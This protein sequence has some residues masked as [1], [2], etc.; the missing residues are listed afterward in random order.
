M[1]THR[2]LLSLLLLSA[3]YA[4]QE[5]DWEDPSILGRNKEAPHATLAPFSDRD[6]ALRGQRERSPW[7]RS[8][9]GPWRFHW[10]A[11][12]EARP[13]DFQR[14]DFDASGWDTIPVPSNWQLEGHGTPIYTNV[15]YP[16][17]RDPPRV[18]GEVPES[19]TKHRLPNPVGSYR[20]T[21]EL[22]GGWDGR[23]VFLHFDGVQSAFYLW[24]NGEE[25]GYSQGSMTPAEF[26]ITP[27]LRP[28]ENVV[29]AQVYRWSDGS[30]LEDQD[31]WRLSGI[32]RDV[33]LFST[34]KLH[35]AD[36]FALPHLDAAFEQGE[37]EVRFELADY[38]S[39]LQE[40]AVRLELLDSDG[41]TVARGAWHGRLAPDEDGRTRGAAS[42]TV[43]RPALWSAESPTLYRLLLF[44][45]DEGG[46]ALEVE[47][48]RVGFRE[49]EIRGELLL[50][51]GTPVKLK[52]VNRH[53]HDPDR[54]HAI[55]RE[56]M[57]QDI[58]L[59]K[60]A[61]VNTVRTSHYPNQPL[62]YELC[63]QYGLYVIDEANLESHGMGYGDASLAH[64]PRWEAAHVDRQVSM[65]ER[66]KNHPCV[67]L[68]SMGNEAG[69]GENFAA[70]R[71]AIR[72]LDTSRPIH[73]E[74]D[75]AKADLDSVMYPSV[76]WLESAGANGSDRPLL[77]CEYA[78]AMGN[79]VGNLAEYWDTIYRHDR[80]LGGCIWDWVDQGLRRRNPD[81]SE[82]FLYGG[83][84][85]DV[86]NDGS[87]CINGLVGPDRAPTP[88][89][90]EV[91]HVY[92]NI[93]TRPDD[94]SL[95]RV[96]IENRFAFTNLSDFE[97][98]WSVRE[99]GR[100]IQ[101]GKLAALTIAPGETETASIPIEPWER[102]PGTESFL[103]VSFHLRTAEPWAP[104]GFEIA[105]DQLPL[106]G[107]T[108]P[109]V[110][111]NLGL[112]PPLRLERE[113]GRT[114][115]L[116]DGFRIVFDDSAAAIVAWEGAG[117]SLLAGVRARPPGPLLNVYRAP[118]NNDRYCLRPWEQEELWHLERA[119][120]SFEVEPI[121]PGLL[122]VRATTTERGRG[123][124]HFEVR[125]TWTILGDG[126]VHTAMNVVPRDAPS[127]LARVGVSM[128]LA[129]ALEELEWFGRG[130]L[131][132]YPD[133][134]TGSEIDRFVSS[135][136]DQFVPY[137][138]PQECGAKCDV[139]WVALRDGEGAGLLVAAA[140][141]FS[142]TAL[143]QTSRELALARHPGD[144]P[145]REDTVL[146]ID[147]AVNGLGGASCGPRPMA[148]YLLR[149]EPL[150]FSFWMRPLPIGADP[151]EMGRRRVPIAPPVTIRRDASGLVTISPDDV[152]VRVRVLESDSRSRPYTGPF[153]CAD[154]AT[155]EAWSVADGFLHGA[156][157]RASFESIVPRGNWQV[158]SVDSE[159]P[160]EGL[161]AHAIDGDAATFWH[162]AW[163]SAAPPPPHE[164]L[165]DLGEPFELS[166]LRI[167]PRQDSSNG[168]IARFEVR[169]ALERD[170]F[171]D[172]I[173][174]GTLVD[175]SRWQEI[176]FKA[177]VRARF[178]R[179][180]ALS[181]VHGRP[182]TTI[183]ELDVVR[184]R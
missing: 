70:C 165:L 1:Q 169:A 174:S 17:H 104:A 28:G 3:P 55:G 133:R 12:P 178:L 154:A 181:E 5:H 120:D 27:Y 142:F 89:L 29:A 35:I 47:T 176:P 44:L 134:K 137:I 79:A 94:L 42:L 106:P 153:L 166:A 73:Y 138:D 115:I 162:T 84:F 37:L 167:L 171:G 51:N 34:P 147:A 16:F 157:A 121:A 164:L 10:V 170:G 128:H 8:L 54:G 82:D 152:Q 102:R 45:E 39:G 118:V 46:R 180:T 113:G 58:E 114:T 144:L 141:P 80:L 63:D 25:V 2:I 59:M 126:T 21:F 159:E 26:R 77:M 78:H 123:A 48:C 62:W 72:S 52:G 93:V 183:A 13:R 119:V 90:G 71:E 97:A 95:G 40:S 87:F 163:S 148:R 158:V 15:T 61:N 92:R 96:R 11:S 7:V 175:S 127:V 57:I 125:S 22:P 100:T 19:W 116:G 155:I 168:R 83:D 81:G 109:P 68:W 65:V 156:V 135:V 32:F 140:T 111:T 49:V 53:E 124:A 50:I 161:A 132:N 66:D 99:D 33:Y 36:F 67:I 173:A 31:F 18:M 43:D 23:E 14:I 9:N 24:V 146:S 76:E 112:L 56:R 179:I 149:A 20:R 117:R 75:N 143:H 41:T 110:H 30:Y 91:R 101:A 64:D 107:P 145:A 182:W 122:Q 136:S 177:P 129:G 130:P 6:D 131:E 184:A 150:A 98:R 4:A 74:R 88:K 151:G 172:P 103:R 108:P 60:R 139:R 105:A 85:G 86:P 38:D 69:P 160:G